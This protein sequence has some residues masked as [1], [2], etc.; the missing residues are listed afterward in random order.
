MRD[1][2]GETNSRQLFLI[3]KKARVEERKNLEKYLLLL[4][5][6]NTF[7][8]PCPSVKTASTRIH[9]VGLNGNQQKFN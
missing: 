5:F 8:N 1:C 9:L 3:K 2:L 4:F 7:A 6:R